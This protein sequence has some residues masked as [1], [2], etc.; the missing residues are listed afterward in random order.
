MKAVNTAAGA[1]NAG[2]P[3]SGTITP[4]LQDPMADPSPAIIE[5]GYSHQ[6]VSSALQLQQTAASEGPT[7]EEEQEEPNSGTA[8][9]HHNAPDADIGTEVDLAQAD[10]D[11][12]DTPAAEVPDESALTQEGPLTQVSSWSVNEGNLFPAHV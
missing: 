2:T 4:Q 5:P 10:A 7:G 6:R 1:T 9:A 12:L 8:D 11:E 3:E